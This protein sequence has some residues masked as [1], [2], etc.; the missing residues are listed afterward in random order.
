MARTGRLELPV[1]RPR[2]RFALTP[3]ADAMF[4]LLIFFMLSSNLTPYALLPV[5]SAPGAPE[6]TQPGTAGGGGEAE[7]PA[8]PQ[9]P[10]AL[11]TLE[12]GA[13]RVGGQR[14]GFDALPA[15]AEALGADGTPADVVVLVRP[16][17]TVQ[18]IATVLESLQAAEVGSVQVA[19]GRL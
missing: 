19:S 17:A 9:A 5:Q 2:Y 12:A 6:V 4:Q 13:V 15:L 11:W 10:T 14:F 7:T 16:G 3:L 18:D 1:R 8:R